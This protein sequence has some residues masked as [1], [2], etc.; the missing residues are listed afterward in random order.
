[1]NKELA[2]S[3]GT[4]ARQARK[5]L[6]LTQEDAADRINVSV[7]FYA[8]IERGASLPSILTFARIVSA[9]GVSADAMLG[10]QP[11]TVSAGMTWTPPAPD[12]SA[13]IRRVMRRLRKASPGTLRLV[14]LLVKELESPRASKQEMAA[15]VTNKPVTVA[16]EQKATE[17]EPVT[18]A[19]A[20]AK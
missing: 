15:L 4:V 17:N 19:V 5:N 13:E 1:M 18:Q 14:N 3:I 16:N 11:M 6:Q 10:R 7:E 2:K 20:V 9:L 12:D 8:R